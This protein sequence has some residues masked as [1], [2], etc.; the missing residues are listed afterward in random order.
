MV[1]GCDIMKVLSNKMLKEIISMV[2]IKEQKYTVIMQ[3]S[4][5]ELA[6]TQPR[7]ARMLQQHGVKAR[8]YV[9]SIQGKYFVVN[10]Y[11]SGKYGDVT[12]A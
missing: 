5:K 9:E 11:Q 8:L 10:Q 6:L 12:P 1:S 2:K 3:E 7:L 4:V